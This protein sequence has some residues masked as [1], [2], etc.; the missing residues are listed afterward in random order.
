MNTGRKA[1]FIH[2][3]IFAAAL[4]GAMTMIA[5]LL[6]MISTSLKQPSEVFTAPPHL[7]PG[8][9][10]WSNYARAWNSIPFGRFYCNSVLV[11][12]C[13]VAGQC[14][15]SAMAG[16]AFARLN[17]RGRDKIFFC[18][19]A[20]LMV[21]GAVTMIPLFIIMKLLGGLWHANIYMFDNIY[22][23]SPLGLNSYFALIVPGFFS[24]YGAFLLRQFFM[25]IPVELDE[26][27]KID[28]GG[29]WTIFSK[30]TVPL[31]MPAVATL[32]IFTL[33]GTWRDF[34]WPLV[35]VNTN[36]LKTLPVGLAAF[37]GLYST[38][39]ALLM[40]ASLIVMAPLIIVFFFAQR[41]FVE[42]IKLQGIKG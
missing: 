32:A 34:I 7:L 29:H 1:R 24:A 36:E 39:W 28:G 30:V 14:L 9:W 21:P 5:P 15:V 20:T 27:T 6:W 33:L 41:F 25:G 26:A 2:G 12:L 8:H 19:L 11:T 31:S 22:M 13:V 37:Q 16:Y 38:D 42:G 23:G 18:Y 35:I 17:F 10:M 40:A 4:F 3:V